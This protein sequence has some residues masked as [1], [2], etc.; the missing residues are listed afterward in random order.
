MDLS[1]YREVPGVLELK[2]I[3]SVV[4]STFEAEYI[5]AGHCCKQLL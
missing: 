5:T 2:E 4:L 3:N 1:V